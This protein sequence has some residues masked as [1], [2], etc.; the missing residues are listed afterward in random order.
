VDRYFF[1]DDTSYQR[2]RP[3]DLVVVVHVSYGVLEIASDVDAAIYQ[4]AVRLGAASDYPASDS[5]ASGKIGAVGIVGDGAYASARAHRSPLA[6]RKTVRYRKI[7]DPCPVFEE[8]AS[9][10]SSAKR[11]RLVV[12]AALDERN[13]RIRRHKAYARSDNNAVRAMETAV[14]IG[15][16]HLTLVIYARRRV[17]DLA[18]GQIRQR[19][20]RRKRFA[21]AIRRIAVVRIVAVHGIHVPVVLLYVNNLDGNLFAES[22]LAL[23][24]AVGTVAF[25]LEQFAAV[26]PDAFDLED[27]FVVAGYFRADSACR[28]R[29]LRYFHKRADCPDSRHTAHP[30]TALRTNRSL[31]QSPTNPASA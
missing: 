7:L 4:F 3:H 20:R 21:G 1:L 23:P 25:E 24:Y 2:L 6:S 19:H 15:G 5:G 12:R 30:S 31:R 29:Y 14:D 17:D 11:I 13:R 18:R 28:L 26:D 9:D 27:G 8:Y 22:E 16:I 10:A